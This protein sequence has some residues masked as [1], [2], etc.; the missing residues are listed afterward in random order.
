MVPIA[1]VMIPSM[2]IAVPIAVIAAPVPPV[3]PVAPEAA[4][5][6]AR[7]QVSESS[8]QEDVFRTS[9]ICWRRMT[10]ERWTRPS[11]LQERTRISNVSVP[12]SFIEY[13]N[14]R[15]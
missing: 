10:L 1:P 14:G 2:V 9:W 11:C 3:V 8:W 6:L 15:R 12:P 13:L 7:L 4:R 5:L